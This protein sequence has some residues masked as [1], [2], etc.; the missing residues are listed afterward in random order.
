M[1]LGLLYVGNALEQLGKKV[2]IV[3]LYLCDFS[4]DDKWCYLKLKEVIDDFNPDIIGFGG[5]ATSYGWTKR[6]SIEF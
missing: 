1:P 5:I 3:D 2:K 4:G 6:L